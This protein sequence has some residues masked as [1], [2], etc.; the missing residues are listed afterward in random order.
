MKKILL[1]CIATF[2]SFLCLA[3]DFDSIE[4]ANGDPIVV[5]T[6][7]SD[8]PRN[9]I[10]VDYVLAFYIDTYYERLLPVSDRMGLILR[11]GHS[12]GAGFHTGGAILGGAGIVYGKNKHLGYLTVGLRHE[13]GDEDPYR[14]TPYTQPYFKLFYRFVAYNNLVINV[15]IEL[16]IPTIGIGYTF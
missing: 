12:I 11:G 9:L 8:F 16:I 4:T 7:I 15:G 2:T 1:V 14:D 6:T 13:Y 3:Q 10:C 5:R